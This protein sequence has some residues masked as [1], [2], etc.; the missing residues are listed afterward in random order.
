M[1]IINGEGMILGRLAA[2]V[3]KEA[4]LGEEINVINCD[5]VVIS[6]N[7]FNVYK[8]EKQKRDRRG[9]PLKSQKLTRMPDRFVRRT[10]RGMLPHKQSRGREAF[11]NV[12]CYIG[13]PEEFSAQAITYASATASKLPT[14]NYVTV[15]EVCKML[16]GKLEW[17]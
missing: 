7:K 13:V 5:K 10:I 16:G 2:L 14:L 12:M 6:G 3:A 8:K 15:G 17:F 1:K 11:K 9:Y 4:L